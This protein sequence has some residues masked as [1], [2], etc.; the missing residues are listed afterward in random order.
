M[1]NLILQRLQQKLQKSCSRCNKN[2]WHV[3]SSY[4]LQPPRYLLLFV[5]RKYLDT[6]IIM[7]PKIHAPYLWVRPLDLVSLI[8]A[9]GLLWIIMDRLYIPIITLHLSIAAKTYYCTDIYIIYVILHKLI[10]TWFLDSNRRVAV[11][12]LPW[13]W[14]ILSAPFTTGRGTG[15]ES[16]GLDDV[17]PPDDLCPH[18]EAMC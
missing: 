13:R 5:N 9:Y 6:L 1:Q 14:D 16:C 10:D 12:S 17:F 8:L 18:P 7:S 3:E 4:I 11:W 2:T 15:A